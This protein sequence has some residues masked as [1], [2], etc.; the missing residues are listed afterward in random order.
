MTARTIVVE[1]V[2]HVIRVR[3]RSKR[4]AMAIE[5]LC[6][7]ADITFAM[8]GNASQLLVRTGQGKLRLVVVK[9]CGRPHRIGMAGETIVVEVAALMVRII[10]LGEVA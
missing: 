8:T 2:R 5:T 3:G 9:R 10:G 1:V 6:G 7:C 4:S